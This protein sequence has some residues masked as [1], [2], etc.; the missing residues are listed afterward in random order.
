MPLTSMEHVPLVVLFVSR[1]QSTVDK[2]SSR[3]R[4]QADPPVMA[5]HV[6]S[7]LLWPGVSVGAGSPGVAATAV[8]H[9]L[10]L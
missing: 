6:A 5:G 9:A 4:F 2:P 1:S 10:S 8:L 3:R 7:I